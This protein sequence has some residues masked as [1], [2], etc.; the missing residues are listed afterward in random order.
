MR[1][2]VKFVADRDCEA[3]AVGGADAGAEEELPQPRHAPVDLRRAVQRLSRMLR[4][5][6]N[7]QDEV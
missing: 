5:R 1:Y 2:L 3:Q 4:R 7:M 6:Y